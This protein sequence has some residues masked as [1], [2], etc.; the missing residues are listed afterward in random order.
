MAGA[1]VPGSLGS[2]TLGTGDLLTSIPVTAPDPMGGGADRVRPEARPLAFTL[3]PRV[4]P[5]VPR[6]K[7]YGCRREGGSTGSQPA[8]RPVLGSRAG[9]KTPWSGA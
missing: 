3:G 9:G 8:K 2:D 7:F 5:P 1:K 6:S 4:R